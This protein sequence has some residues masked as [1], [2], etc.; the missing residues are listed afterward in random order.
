MRL[1]S[2]VSLR[3]IAGY[4]ARQTARARWAHARRR[5]RESHAGLRTSISV[6]A[7]F[8]AVGA[9]GSCSS[10][11]EPG[12]FDEHQTTDTVG[13]TCGDWQTSDGKTRPRSRL[14]VSCGAGLTCVD[15][16]AVFPDDELG[17]H[18]GRC[19]PEDDLNCDVF[20]PLNGLCRAGLTCI[21]GNSAPLPGQCFF[22]CET[23]GDCPGPFQ[24]CASG[25]C[26]FHTCTL[27]GSNPLIPCA[28]GAVCKKLVCV[29]DAPVGAF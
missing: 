22:K 6:L 16:V 21:A 19:M 26:Q 12:A 25:G 2:C 23:H 10:P 20:D 13:A 4:A 28:N 8:S 29:P 7:L 18:F 5:L 17:N 11:E 1:C 15:G 14:F 9:A 24:V 3:L 27:P